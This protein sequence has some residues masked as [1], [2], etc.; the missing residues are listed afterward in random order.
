MTDPTRIPHSPTTEE[1]NRIHEGRGTD[2]PDDPKVIHAMA[3][4]LLAY[5]KA[6]EGYPDLSNLIYEFPFYD[7]ASGITARDSLRLAYALTATGWVT[8]TGTAYPRLPIVRNSMGADRMDRDF[9]R[10]VIITLRQILPVGKPKYWDPH[11]ERFIDNNVHSD[12]EVFYDFT[13]DIR[14]REYFQLFVGHDEVNEDVMIVTDAADIEELCSLED[15]ETA[16][17]AMLG[18]LRRAYKIQDDYE[19][20]TEGEVRP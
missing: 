14:D 12:K 19:A 15:V 4:E 16:L 9:L 2:V 6:T 5:R 11:K 10:D 8:S 18:L 1:L 3:T 13:P 17:M 7:G 20:E